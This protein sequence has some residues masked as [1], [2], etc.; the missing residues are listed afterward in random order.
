ML[1]TDNTDISSLSFYDYDIMMPISPELCV[2]LFS[3]K[4]CD[5]D[6]LDRTMLLIE[7]EYE[8][9]FLKAMMSSSDM[10]ISNKMSENT[11]QKI[12]SIYPTV[13]KNRE[14]IKEEQEKAREKLGL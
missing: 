9:D 12:D 6:K 11:K 3:K 7:K 5:N 10:L 1:T 14:M 8:D 13:L 2:A 4:V